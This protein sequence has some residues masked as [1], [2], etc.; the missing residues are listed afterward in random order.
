PYEPGDHSTKYQGQELPAWFALAQSLNIPAV[1][2]AEMV[3]YKEVVAMAH[4]AGLNEDIKPTPSVA[5]GSYEVMPIEIA[6][7]YTVFAN[8][9]TLVQSSYIKSIRSTNGSTIFSAKP[10]RKYAMDPRVAY[11]VENTM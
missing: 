11:L 10:E 3:G 4:A 2:V 6:Q 8:R 5:L 1:K 7:A 9:G